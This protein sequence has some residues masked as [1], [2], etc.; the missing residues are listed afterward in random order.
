MRIMPR[1]K[2]SSA[3]AAKITDKGADEVEGME[4][5]RS[6]LRNS[7]RRSGVYS[8]TGEAGNSEMLETVLT[9]CI[10]SGVVLL[11][12]LLMCLV[13]TEFTQNIRMSLKSAIASETRL[14]EIVTVFN[15]PSVF[16]P[17]GNTTPFFMDAPPTVDTEKS[18][19]ET[20]SAMNAEQTENMHETEKNIGAAV[21][22]TAETAAVDESGDLRIDEDI[23]AEINSKTDPYGEN[24]K[25]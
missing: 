19:M 7:A 18:T 22:D 25:K 21:S 14:E 5:R 1:D 17:D 9:Q 12:I 3:H 20:P 10:I 2:N 6:S 8:G 23:L 4:Y 13:K 24:L 15:I 11:V 16:L